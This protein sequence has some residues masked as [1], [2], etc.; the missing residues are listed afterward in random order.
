MKRIIILA[1]LSVATSSAFSWSH[2]D[3]PQNSY[4]YSAENST[5][6]K[7]DEMQRRL[8]QADFERLM[9]LEEQRAAAEEAQ[10]AARSEAEERAEQARQEAE[11]RAA[12]IE[13]KERIAS[14]RNRTL[15]YEA[16]AILAF[17]V[18]SYKVIRD[19]HH[20][21]ENTLKPHEKAGVVIGV[22]GGAIMLSALF[23]SSPWTPHLDF[24]QNIMQEFMTIDVWPYVQTKFII[25][26]CIG[27]ISY[28]A[29]VYLE[30]LKAPKFLL[31]RFES[32]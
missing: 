1:C 22:M 5:Q 25:L 27:L 8:D 17:M 14:A 6:S 7:L 31:S 26:S 3:Q 23:V 30:I 4:L 16:L 2:S 13:K 21:K 20:S 12:E 19:K 28:G 15:M 10:E 18:A 29:M 32:P 9:E 11:D 24:W